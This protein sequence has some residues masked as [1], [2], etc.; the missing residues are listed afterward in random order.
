MTEEQLLQ[1]TLPKVELT[2]NGTPSLRV[3]STS[4]F[5]LVAKNQDQL[6]LNGLIARL[7]IPNSVSIK[8]VDA[9]S[10]ETSMETDEQGGNS[11]VWQ[12]ENLGPGETRSMRFD[13]VASKPEHF[14]IDVEWTALPQTASSDLQ[15]EQPML[16]IAL[17]GSSE[18]IYGRPEIY[19]LRIRN[20][21]NADAKSVDV[22]LQAD[23]FGENSTNI[24]DVPAGAERMV[25]VELT[26][27]H[28]G[29][30]PISAIA[31][32]TSMS[33]ESS[34]K[35]DV[36]V[37]QA[38]LEMEWS[39]P[40]SQYQGS[41][42][43]YSVSLHNRSAMTSE[44]IQCFVSIPE[45][46]SPVSLPEGAKVVGKE[47]TW[48]VP[49]LDANQSLSFPI[50]LQ[51]NETGAFAIQLRCEGS[52]GGNAQ[53][54]ATVQVDSI[55]D[56]KLSVIDPVAPAPVGS[57]VTYEVVVE[58]RGSKEATGVR[59]LAQF[60]NGIEPVKANGHSHQL[61]PGQVVFEPI[62]SIPAGQSVRLQV[63]ALASEAGMHRF[64]AEV[65]CDD[66]DTQLLH[67]ESTRYLASKR[68][69]STTR[70]AKTTG[71]SSTYQR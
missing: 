22:T 29:T 43:E 46:T 38:A 28:A 59:V 60:S 51:T 21:G 67:E 66:Q 11:L 41:I 70:S 55:S 19:R 9:N 27:Q 25:E 40:E 1:M 39:G 53:S 42:S 23:S 35:I 50:E 15:V 24:G 31:R 44:N 33:L 56:L 36:R 20:P 68:S 58:N 18:V 64:R 30:M 52:A 3:N 13:L 5:E 7:G 69:D 48:R 49:R 62:P 10:D 4:S 45:G 61:V 34:T 16:Q 71:S 37:Q 63:T 6:A 8:L 65:S 17:E 54:T 2:L 12:I 47:I 32:S 26:F 14:A 57:N